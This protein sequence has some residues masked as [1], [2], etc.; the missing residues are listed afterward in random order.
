[1]ERDSRRDGG[2]GVSEEKKH[3]TRLAVRRGEPGG[4][5]WVE[6]YEVPFEPGLTLLDALIWVRRHQDPSLAVRYSCR[7]N[8]CKECSAIIDGQPGYLCTQRAAEDAT[9]SIEPLRK[10]RLI[11]DLVTELK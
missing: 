11:R 5:P 9:A 2:G 3:V 6:E 7:A 8:A 4:E 10:P 1:M